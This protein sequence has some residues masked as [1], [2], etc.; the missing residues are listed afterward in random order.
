MPECLG[1]MVL[2]FEQLRILQG[3]SG[4][5][6]DAFDDA[7]LLA[8][9]LVASAGLVERDV[10]DHLVDVDERNEQHQP[11]TVRPGDL[12]IQVGHVG[13]LVVQQRRSLRDDRVQGRSA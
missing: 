6:G 2:P 3:H 12:A 7:D 4:L 13:E 5:T 10:A 1:D 9:E 8:R 11:C